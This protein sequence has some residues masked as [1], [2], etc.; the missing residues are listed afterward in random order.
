MSP[1]PET[2]PLLIQ[3]EP[4]VSLKV[5]LSRKVVSALFST[6]SLRICFLVQH[7]S[8]RL[9]LSRTYPFSEHLLAHPRGVQ[10]LDHNSSV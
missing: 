7:E 10:T 9:D 6:L 4:L 5:L 1:P 2:F 8:A 3:A